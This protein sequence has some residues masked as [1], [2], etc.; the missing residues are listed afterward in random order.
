VQRVLDAVRKRR[1]PEPLK[2]PGQRSGSGAKS[3]EPYLEQGR[4]SRPAPLE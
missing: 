2:P 3:L 4:K 1:P